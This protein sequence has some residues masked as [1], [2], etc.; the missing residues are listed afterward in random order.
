MMKISIM[1][2]FLHSSCKEWV[3][4][5][6]SLWNY[7]EG[8]EQFLRVSSNFIFK[9]QSENQSFILRLTPGENQSKLKREMDFL[10][11]LSTNG[12]TVNMPVPSVNGH[13]IEVINTELGD[14]QAVVFN[15]FEGEQIEIGGIS[16]SRMTAWGKALGSI[17][18][19]SRR[20]R[21]NTDS[22]R[23]ENLLE[24]HV[25][26]L[27]K[28][29]HQEENYLRG[30]LSG[31]QKNSESYGALHFDLELD[32]V[33]WNGDIPQ[34]IDFES[35]L[36][37]W[38][39]ADVAFA[40][41]DLFEDGIDL[42]GKKF[43]LF[44]EGYRKASALSDQEIDNLPMFLRLHNLITYKGLL[45]TLDVRLDPEQPEWVNELITKLERKLNFYEEGFN[46]LHSS[47]AQ[48]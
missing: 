39:A 8:S 25:D 3:K 20:A 45:G 41:R 38:Y 36:T 42:Q 34:I 6:L 10:A 23:L 12:L 7:N 48:R 9:F 5:A 22:L 35:G 16:N 19:V 17:H 30:W 29:A 43:A 31:L 40:L 47:Q 37:G 2:D 11:V 28:S 46:S 24:A 1:R 44:L 21:L 27:P 33:I 26:V 18:S 4:A 13:L 15:Y 32:N 14:F